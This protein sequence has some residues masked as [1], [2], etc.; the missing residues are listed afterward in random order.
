[1]GCCPSSPYKADHAATHH[2]HHH[3]PSRSDPSRRSKVAPPDEETVK[4]VLSETPISKTNE[5]SED[6][7]RGGFTKPVVLHKHDDPIKLDNKA[8]FM[9]NKTA[10]EAS[11]V[12]E[13]C[14]LSEV[15]V[16]TAADGGDEVRQRVVNRSP[17]KFRGRERL[18]RA[19]S[20]GKSPARRS[21]PSPVRRSD[22]SPGRVRSVSGT[23]G[24]RRDMGERSGRR[25][26]SPVTRAVAADGCGRVGSGRSSSARRT[27][28]SPGR[29]PGKTRKFEEA[30]EGE[31]GNGNSSNKWQPPTGDESLENPLVSLECFIFL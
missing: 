17:A 1:M 6:K 21:D 7:Q 13:I 12:S 30:T 23:D 29:V 8:P 20:G 18:D 11:E 15:S 14:S 28:K 9:N 5:H 31:I 4:E 27:G 24:R 26:M 3:P 19:A 25:S 2:H 16:S 22:P 10:E